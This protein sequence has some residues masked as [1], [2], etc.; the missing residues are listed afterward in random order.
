MRFIRKKIRKIRNWWYYHQK[1]PA[2]RERLKPLKQDKNSAYKVAVFSHEMSA[3]GAPVMLL[4]VAKAILKDG[5]QVRVFSYMDG[6]LRSTFESLGIEVFVHPG[7][8]TN[9]SLI[10]EFAGDCDYAIA[11]TVVTYPV[12]SLLKGPQI[13]WW[14]HES[15]VIDKDYIARYKRKKFRPDL[16]ASLGM[17]QRVAVVTEYS[18]QVVQKYSSHVKILNLAIEDLFPEGIP[19]REPHQPIRFSILGA[20]CP[21]KGQD[22][23]LKAFTGL[24]EEYQKQMTLVIAGRDVDEFSADL[25]EKYS[26]HPHVEWGN[27]IPYDKL[28]EFYSDSDVILVSSRDESFS[29]VALE[30]CMAGKPL[31]IST[32]V[33]A[34]FLVTPGENGFIFESENI[35]S[36]QKALIQMLENKHRLQEMGANSRKKYI[37][38]GTL[39]VFSQK[40][41]QMMK[42]PNFD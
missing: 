16:E 32:N 5:G 37:E 22:V 33:G 14:V 42:S 18:K 2:M 35:E 25:K 30:A 41:L 3:T 20:V 13:L 34:K 38:N 40:F 19:Q 11:N 39:E 28:K 31:I 8:R 26:H 10:N 12:I 29:L 24:P 9:K 17:A 15:Q 1:L 23:A 21:I 27:S 7:F 36:L 4:V 6:A